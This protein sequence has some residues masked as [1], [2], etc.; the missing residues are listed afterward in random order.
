MVSEISAE[1]NESDLDKIITSLHPTPAVCGLPKEEAKRFII[2]NEGYD[3]DFYTGFVG[4]LNCDFTNL[5]RNTD[6]FVNLRCMKIDDDIANIFVGCGITK[7]SI[8]EKEYLESVN[9]S[10]TMKRIV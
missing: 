4:E 6:L 3:R 9:K 8:P 1:I 10:F 5:K 2:E 7:D